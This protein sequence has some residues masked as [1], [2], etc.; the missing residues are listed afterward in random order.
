MPVL[1]TDRMLAFRA[2][3]EQS[4]ER[5]QAARF[6]VLQV[7]E[8]KRAL[9][10]QLRRNAAE[11][12]VPGASRLTPSQWLAWEQEAALS[13]RALAAEEEFYLAYRD[14]HHSEGPPIINPALEGLRFF[15]G[16]WELELSSL[17]S[18]IGRGTVNFEWVSVQAFMIVR[19]HIP[20]GWDGLTASTAFFGPGTHGDD[21]TAHY[22]NDRGESRDYFMTLND[23]FWMLGNKTPG[24][25]QRFFGDILERGN[26][27]SGRWEQSMDGN[28]WEEQCRA[29][30]W[31]NT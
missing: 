21:Y 27:I 15:E 13:R 24:V 5:L 7:Q 10:N 3:R 12:E 26:Y 4:A 28:V 8:D 9:A 2:S 23:D 1:F 17:D 18:G 30:Y 16:S 19:T 31:R 20:S 29:V 22:A 6:E 25:W 11:V 14:F